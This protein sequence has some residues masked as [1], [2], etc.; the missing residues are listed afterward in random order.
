M[1]FSTAL[2][3]NSWH[4]I[5]LTDNRKHLKHHFPKPHEKI[6]QYV[7]KKRYIEVLLS[8]KKDSFS[9]IYRSLTVKKAINSSKLTKE[10]II[11]N[12]IYCKTGNKIICFNV[13]V[14]SDE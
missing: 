8:L 4:T 6:L 3:Y 1:L 10:G 14:Q 12:S 7:H 11:I 9:I 2:H 13:C 5:S